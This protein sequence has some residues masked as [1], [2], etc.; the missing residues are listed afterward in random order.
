MESESVT[1]LNHSIFYCDL[2]ML[3]SACYCPHDSPTVHLSV[4]LSLWQAALSHIPPSL[5]C[6]GPVACKMVWG[7]F[8]LG[9]GMTDWAERKEYWALNQPEQLTLFFCMSLLRPLCMQVI[10]D[11]CILPDCITLNGLIFR[12][13]VHW[14]HTNNFLLIHEGHT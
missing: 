9:A 7:E 5:I 8:V 4:C 11:I 1:C 10:Y 12:T 2:W 3:L 6:S 13:Q 14:F